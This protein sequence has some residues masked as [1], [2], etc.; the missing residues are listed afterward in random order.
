MGNMSTSAL[1]TVS[2]LGTAASVGLILYDVAQ[3]NLPQVGYDAVDAT[4]GSVVTDAG[5]AG[6]IPSGGGSIATAAAILGGYVWLGG[7]KG[8]VQ[9][10][11]SVVSSQQSQT[12]GANTN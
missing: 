4:V 3:N 8:I 2:N 10:I 5:V 1:E 7:S 6:S 9:S 11:K 12:C